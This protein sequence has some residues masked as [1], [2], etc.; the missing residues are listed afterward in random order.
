MSE[1]AA[2]PTPTVPPIVALAELATFMNAPSL[3]DGSTG[4]L[5]QEILNSAHEYVE[6]AVGPLDSAARSYRV[7]AGERTRSLVLPVTHLEE[8]VSVTSP[9]GEG[10]VVDADV[11]VNYLA[12]I[13]EIP[14]PIKGSWYV[15]VR[16]RDT[17]DSFVQAVKIIASHLYETQRGSGGNR[18]AMEA[19]PPASTG[20]KGFAI[21][22]RAAQLL[23]PYLKNPGVA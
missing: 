16:T 9:R 19:S 2:T 1:P 15:S 10:V 12:G 18:L 13:V 8:L 5:L 7:Y 23:A 14:R 6:E 4:A 20:T 22:H 21:P 17:K 3:A 11:D